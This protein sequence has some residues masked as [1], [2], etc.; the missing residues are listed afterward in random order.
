[1]TVAYCHCADCRRASGAPVAA[2]AAFPEDLVE[3]TSEKVAVAAPNPGVRRAFC[4]ACGSPIW[5]SYDYIPGQIY[6][7]LG[8]LDQAADLA[9]KLHAHADERL[10][11]LHIDDKLDR[12]E[13][14]SRDTLNA[15]TGSE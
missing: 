10:T 5:S 15:S 14:S 12:I 2:F 7:S 6:V 4:S 9:P 11:W 3:I 13:G 1:M 8:L